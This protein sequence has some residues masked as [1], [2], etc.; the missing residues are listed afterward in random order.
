[1]P[2]NLIFDSMKTF[3]FKKNIFSYSVSQIPLYLSLTFTGLMLL[4]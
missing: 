1:M 4:L 3:Q 2:F